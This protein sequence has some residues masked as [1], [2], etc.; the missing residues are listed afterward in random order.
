MR[1]ITEPVQFRFPRKNE[2]SIHAELMNKRASPGLLVLTPPA[3]LLYMNQRAQE[4]TTQI[5]DNSSETGGGGLKRAKGLLPAILLEVCAAT[6]KHLQKRTQVKD[7]ERFE[8]RRIIG[9]KRPV[10]I[11]ITGIPDPSQHL[12]P[13]IVVVMEEVG[14][15]KEEINQQQKQHFHFSEREQVVVQCLAKGWTNKEIACA[16]GNATTTVREHIRHIMVKT[17]TTTRSGILGQ[18]LHQ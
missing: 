6:L 13:L 1:G 7:W 11:R 16:L 2:N 5:R 18:V 15:R 14:R 4:L 10:L 3:T 9:S 17:H 12:Q 8:V